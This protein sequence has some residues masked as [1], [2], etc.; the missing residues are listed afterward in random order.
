[1]FYFFSLF[2][3]L[4]LFSNAVASGELTS[5]LISDK[6]AIVTVHR[7][8]QFGFDDERNLE[9]NYIFRDQDFEALAGLIL[10]RDVDEP[11]CKLKG[12]F[13]FPS[14]GAHG[15]TIGLVQSGDELCFSICQG[16]G[17]IATLNIKLTGVFDEETHVIL[18][19]QEPRA[20]WEGIPRAINGTG[21]SMGPRGSP[22]NED[23]DK[24]R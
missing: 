5:Q 14:L 4:I 18:E 16:N 10:I 19:G 9:I 20:P 13:S 7:V 23:K 24:A 1:M 8:E 6:N 11:T 12:F 15:W 3:A 17:Y 2:V 22:L 21:P